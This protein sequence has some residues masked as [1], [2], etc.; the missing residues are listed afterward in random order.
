MDYTGIIVD[1][2]RIPTSLTPA[3]TKDIN[4]YITNVNYGREVPHT[5]SYTKKLIHYPYLELFYDKINDTIKMYYETHDDKYSRIFYYKY[6]PTTG[7]IELKFYNKNITVKLKAKGLVS[8]E[9]LEA[10]DDIAVLSA[11][12]WYVE[13]D[14][15]TK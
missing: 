1:L 12:A 3:I 7:E 13:L 14:M 10:Q 5:L 6:V 8:E 2:C 4:T 9:S 15:C 11:I